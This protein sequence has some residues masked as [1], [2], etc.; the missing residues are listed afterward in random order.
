MKKSF[1]LFSILLIGCSSPKDE[2]VTPIKNQEQ[3]LFQTPKNFPSPIYELSS[4]PVNQAGFE[5]GKELFNEP[6]LSRD[7]TIACAECHNQ[8]YAFT[9]HGHDVSHG[10]DNR[11]GSRNA[12]PIQN[13]AWQKEFFW[14][15]G[16][17]NL[18]LFSI[19][20]IENPLEMDENIGNVLG[21]LRKSTRYPAL[22]Q[23][24]FGTSEI[25]TQRFLKAL[26][27]FML[28]LVSANSR[29]DKYVRNEGEILGTNEL[30]GL[31]LFQEKCSSCHAGQLFT[32]QTYRNN[33]LYMQGSKDQGRYRI[34]EIET[35]KYKF[36]VPSLRN[37][38]VTGPYMH[39]GRFLT[40]DAVLEHYNTGVQNTQNLDPLLA[41]KIPMTAE[42]KLQII[43][44]LRTLT[45]KA[46]LTNPNFSAN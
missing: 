22:F 35:D 5:L 43:A 25:N 16:V 41:K 38:D 18:D 20:P 11:V 7:N 12:P 17:G 23:K 40:L 27:Q 46:F 39:D 42:E 19:A 6:M 14:D 34:T 4:N 26:S 36:K 28:T 1:L 44:F 21:K 32:D 10:I 24:A 8:A 30:K 33:G 2:P 37:I 9:H 15:G 31:K 3:T 13:M 45:D 29:Y